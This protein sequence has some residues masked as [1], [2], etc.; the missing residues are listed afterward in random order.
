[1]ATILL[2]SVA[3]PFDLWFEGRS[4]AAGHEVDHLRFKAGAIEGALVLVAAL[5][6]PALLVTGRVSPNDADQRLLTWTEAVDGAS[7]ALAAAAMNALHDALQRLAARHDGADSGGV[8]ADFFGIRGIAA[9]AIECHVA[10]HPRNLLPDVG[11]DEPLFRATASAAFAG[12]FSPP[13][14]AGKADAYVALAVELDRAGVLRLLPRIDVPELPHLSLA[15]SKHFADQARPMLRRAGRLPALFHADR[16]G[17][18]PPERRR[19]RERT[20]EEPFRAAHRARR[21]AARVRSARAAKPHRVPGHRRS[22]EPAGS[23]IRCMHIA[24][25][26]AWH[27]AKDVRLSRPV[28]RQTRPS[29]SDAVDVAHRTKC[30]CCRRSSTF[31]MQRARRHTALIDQSRCRNSACWATSGEFEQGGP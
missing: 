18:V 26:G 17:R 14:I 30:R 5:P 22:A 10:I 19:V 13:F 8:S 12:R 25:A 9:A 3:E 15:L 27:V 4:T 21:S 29:F 7:K 24:K 16:L 23:S 1:M 31:R 28:G 6:V 11:A 20:A 2:T